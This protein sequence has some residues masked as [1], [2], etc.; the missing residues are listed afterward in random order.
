MMRSLHY[1][2][3]MKAYMAGHVCPSVR[4]I[5]VENHLTDLDEIWYGLMPLGTTLKSYF[6]VSYNT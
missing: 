6:S 4:M 3:E 2:H 5:Q 1:V